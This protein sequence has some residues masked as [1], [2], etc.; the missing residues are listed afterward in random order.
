MPELNP[1]WNLIDGVA[2]NLRAPTTF[3]IPHESERATLAPGVF[4]KIGV[5]SAEVGERF[6]VKVQDRSPDDGYV[7]VVSNDL[8]YSHGLRDED[9][10]VVYPQHILGILP[11]EDGDNA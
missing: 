5:E 4:A 7:V 1:G 8:V 11:S 3:E 10:L 2:R 6:W 9:V